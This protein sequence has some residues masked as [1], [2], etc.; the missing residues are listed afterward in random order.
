MSDSSLGSHLDLPIKKTA[1]IVNQLGAGLS[2]AVEID[3]IVID[4]GEYAFL[5]VKVKKVKDR[6]DYIEDDDGATDGCVLVQ[7][8]NAVGATFAD[9]KL[10]GAAVH[11]M[12]G[13]VKEAEALRK[14][15]QQAFTLP[16]DIEEELSNV[17]QIR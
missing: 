16:D 2:K 9:E 1:I 17:A 5:A 13:K 3:P 14:S 11:K 7:I 12:M 4:A 6:Y 8:F 15:G 10:I